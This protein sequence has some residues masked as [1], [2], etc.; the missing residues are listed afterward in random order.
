MIEQIE[1]NQS[2]INKLGMS[3][4][5]E[6]WDQNKNRY[7]LKSFRNHSIDICYLM[8][9]NAFFTPYFY[10]NLLSEAIIIN[11]Q[12]FPE[13]PKKISIAF[14]DRSQD[15]QY[16]CPCKKSGDQI[17]G[18]ASRHKP[19]AVLFTPEAVLTE[20]D[21]QSYLV[22]PKFHHSVIHEI[23]HIFLHEMTN[24][25]LHPL[26]LWFDEGVTFLVNPNLLSG[27]KP[28]NLSKKRHAFNLLTQTKDFPS[29]QYLA[30]T[31]LGEN[32][33]TLLYP[34][35]K[36]FT[37]WLF[38]GHPKEKTN[39]I[40]DYREKYRTSKQMLYRTLTEMTIHKNLLSFLQTVI[41][42][43]ETS[44]DN[45]FNEYFGI[46]KDNAYKEF[47]DLLDQMVRN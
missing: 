22:L 46:S 25:L 18:T 29:D 16:F 30:N 20:T 6:F 12:F 26:P 21:C 37:Y 44:F 15:Y 38:Q 17:V 39:A 5:L 19:Q 7:Q 43:P 24:G 10:E 45:V 13:K 42:Q 27:F 14:V 36:N 4:I 47:I 34:F 3:G 8:P 28:P 11:D 32:K 33:S 1:N 31:Y 41:S 23:S 2:K 40:N 9:S 35:A